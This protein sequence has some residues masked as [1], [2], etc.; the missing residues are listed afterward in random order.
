M[1]LGPRNKVVRERARAADIFYLSS[2]DLIH[3][4]PKALQTYFLRFTIIFRFIN[5]NINIKN[6]K[7]IYIVERM[8]QLTL[9]VKKKT[10]PGFCAQCL[11]VRLI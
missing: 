4:V 7:I 10:N 2:Y 8:K 9:S 5:I 3:Y 6:A 1:T 11:T